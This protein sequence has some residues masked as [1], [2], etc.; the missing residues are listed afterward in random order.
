[1]VRTVSRDG[2]G[3]TVSLDGIGRTVSRSES[4]TGQLHSQLVQPPRH[5]APPA[6]HH[7]PARPPPAHARVRRALSVRVARQ[8]ALHK[9][10]L[11]P[12]HLRARVPARQHFFPKLFAKNFSLPRHPQSF[13]FWHCLQTPA[14]FRRRSVHV[15]THRHAV[16]R[17]HIS[18]RAIHCGRGQ[19]GARLRRRL[20]KKNQKKKTRF[21]AAGSY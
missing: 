1:M 20:P 10:P 19:V 7:G 14:R 11:G 6:V 8:R 18:T 12:S 2:I 16:S 5:P 21:L 4:T 15:H 13:S 9:R 17:N 3:R